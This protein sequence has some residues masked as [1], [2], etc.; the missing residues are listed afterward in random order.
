M[1]NIFVF[2]LVA[3]IMASK[4]S[5]AQLSIKGNITQQ[6]TGENLPGA[7]IY[8][9]DLKRVSSADLQGKYSIENIKPGNYLLEVSMVGFKKNILRI[10]LNRDTIINFRL[11][12]SI[13]EMQE[14]VVTAVTRDTEIK[15]SPVVIK[16]IDMAKLY[17][18]SSTNLIDALK[19]VP[20]VDQITTGTGISKPTIRGL[21]YNRLISLYNGIRQEGQQWGDEHGIEI[22]EYS[23]ERVEIVK[24]P[25]SLMY[26]SDGIAGVLNFL[27]PKSP[28]KGEIITQLISNYQSN[29]NF[30]GNS[31]SNAGNINGIN[32]LGRLSN[33]FAGNYQNRFDG[34]VYNS[35]FRE[36]NGN[37]FVGLTK[38]W[39]YMHLN[40]SSYNINLNMSEGERDKDGRFVYEKFD[41]NDSLITMTA[42]DKD[43][44][45]YHIG[46]PYQKVHHLRFLTNSMFLLN[47]GN[48]YVDLGFQ[49][50]R[51]KE[52][53]HLAHSH[54]ADHG[55][56]EE[57]P[58]LYFNLNTL[59]YNFRFNLKER[60]G[61][62]HSIGLGGMYQ[63]NENLGKEFMI[64]Q[65][66]LIDAGAF[67]FT[68]KTF[69]RLTFAS[70]IRLENRNIM[71]RELRLDSTGI[72]S[73]SG[74]IKFDPI[75]ENYSGYAGS[76]GMTWQVGENSTFKANLSRG[77]RA[78]NIAEISSNGNHEGTLRYEIGNPKLDPE[79]SHQIDLAYFIN[80]DH[81]TF[82]LTPFANRISNY[83]FA[84]KLSSKSGG[85]SI[86]NPD[87]P[88]A[89]AFKF[90]QGNTLLLG[91]EIFLD[92]H[93]HPLDWLHLEQS[94]SYVQA[95]QYGQPD[96]TRYLPFI[97]APRYRGEIKA[98]FN[99][100]G[101][102][103]RNPYF[104]IGIEH[105]FAQN[106]FFSAYNTETATPSYT[107]INAGIGADLQAFGRKDFLRIFISG[108]NLADKAFQSHLSR[109]KYT[110]INLATGRNGI[111][112]MGRNISIKVIFNF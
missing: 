70:G 90:I 109:L 110:P 21:G 31:L 38:N 12:L 25:G 92:M 72:E 96:S 17:Q 30:I 49:N 22:D 71:T 67:F 97:P 73:S 40:A 28:P 10:Q 108:E 103:F 69:G 83:I 50:N 46:S 107:L 44:K 26:G 5:H 51:R 1:K 35:G 62:H 19:V 55:H 98:S 57:E 34:K 56:D 53:G 8:L 65:Y 39:G 4:I 58:D 112:N 76:V 32:W 7:I 77:F 101:K 105:Y 84:E 111:F 82:E 15:L 43:L 89:P 75:N 61:W 74:D 24:G 91:G 37:A 52:F 86:P 45:G 29:A 42:S 80:S 18:N 68:D 64:P 60:N 59:N 63:T 47:K 2:M 85:D 88:E 23:I 11:S 13:A 102:G 106:R 87:A 94:F 95:T 14:V 33:K 16:P 3:F 93:P 27:S 81:I 6:E 9:S 79:I 36:F 104:K 78:P 48:L 54:G 99:K 100:L 66:G 20:G 41:E